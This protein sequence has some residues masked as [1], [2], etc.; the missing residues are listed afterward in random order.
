MRAEF[1]LDAFRHL[2]RQGFLGLKPTGETVQD[3]GEFRDADDTAIG[4]VGDMR[5][6]QNWHHVM[7]AVAFQPDIA[8]HHHI[9]IALDFFKRATQQ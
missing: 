7:F 4:H 5:D 1:R 3:A 2:R 9:V 6:S 8:Q